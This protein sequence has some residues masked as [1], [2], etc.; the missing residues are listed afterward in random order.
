MNFSFNF[1]NRK[2]FQKRSFSQSGEDLIIDFIFNQIGIPFPTYLDIGAH[3]PYYLSNTALFYLKGCRGINVEPDPSLF[4]LFES[5]RKNDI[6]LNIGVS[7]KKGELDFYLMNVPTLNTFSID[8]VKLC[9]QEGDYHVDRIARIKVDT[10]QHI[11]DFYNKGLFPDFLTIDAEGI[12]EIILGSI[13]FG[14]NKPIVIC[15]ET[16]SFSGSGRGVKNFQ[17]NNNLEAKGYMLYADTNIN[18]IFVLSDR[19]ER[20]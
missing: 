18:S 15:I 12:D 1:G 13:D 11:L 2:K 16:L 6:N 3:H 14:E 17:I 7:D 8:E 4:K 19:W 9:E 5:E 20:N 10:V